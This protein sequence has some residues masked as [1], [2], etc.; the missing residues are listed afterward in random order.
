MNWK[1]YLKE[2]SDKPI[3]PFIIGPTA[4]GKSAAALDLALEY[5]GEIISA[6]SMQIYK[7]MDIGTAKP[8]LE[9][10]QGIKHHLI[11]IVFPDEE[12]SVF[13]FSQDANQILTNLISENRL[14]IVCGGTGLYINSLIH[15]YN[16]N[17]KTSDDSIRK[18]LEKVAKSENGKE[19]LYS[20]LLRIDPESAKKIHPNNIKRVI[21]ALEIYKVT[22]ETKSSLDSKSDENELSYKP[23][24]LSPQIDR[25]ELYNKINSRV[26]I[27]LDQGLLDEVKKLDSKYD[28]KLISMQAI[29]YKE[30]FPYFDNKIS[31]EE[32]VDTLKKETRHYAKRQL[33][34]FKKLKNINYF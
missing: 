18:E 23:V 27:M 29:G 17:N 25:E 5:N 11:D 1:N 32:A 13:H 6:D 4:S 33:T 24:L 16:H 3:V 7:E 22:G 15:S 10:Q 19:L 20:E 14:P 2:S 34:W 28:R 9:E 31:L 21:R 12:Y 8:S 26:D 30:F